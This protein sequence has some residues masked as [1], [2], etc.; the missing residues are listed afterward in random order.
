MS[1]PV[2][3]VRDVVSRLTTV[4]D[5]EG[6]GRVVGMHVTMRTLFEYQG[7]LVKS[8]EGPSYIVPDF[9]AL[10]DVMHPSDQDDM[11]AALAAKIAARP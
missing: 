2:D 6:T 7:A 11:H 4:V 8:I 3:N 9:D 5:W 10:A 1:A